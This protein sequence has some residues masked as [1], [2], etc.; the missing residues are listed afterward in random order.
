MKLCN[1]FII[2]SC[3]FL[4]SFSFSAAVSGQ[5]SGG[6]S[7]A[8]AQE[9][10]KK[11]CANCG[12]PSK[13]S[14]KSCGEVSYCSKPCQI[15]DW[16]KDHK[17]YHQ[18]F[19]LA[20]QFEEAIRS[21]HSNTDRPQDP[22]D[23]EKIKN[24]YRDLSCF[25]EKYTKLSPHDEAI[26]TCI[27][28]KKILS[29]D[30]L[31]IFLKEFFFLSEIF[32]NLP[33][34]FEQKME[35]KAIEKMN[36][37]LLFLSNS[38]LSAKG[39]KLNSLSKREHFT[40]F[41]NILE[42]T[43]SSS[44]VEQDVWDIVRLILYTLEQNISSPVLKDLLKKKPLCLEVL[45][46]ILKKYSKPTE[47][48]QYTPPCET[49]TV[50][51]QKDLFERLCPV[52]FSNNIYD[53][54]IFALMT[55]KNYVDIALNVP[56][57]LTKDLAPY[58]MK[59][60][61]KEESLNLL[62]GLNAYKKFCNA[63]DNIYTESKEADIPLN[64][65]HFD[66][67]KSLQHFFLNNET[68]EY[69]AEDLNFFRIVNLLNSFISNCRELLEGGS[70]ISSEIKNEKDHLIYFLLKKILEKRRGKIPLALLA[71][72]KLDHDIVKY[73]N[74]LSAAYSW[75]NV[76]MEPLVR[77]A[78]QSQI[79]QKKSKDFAEALSFYSEKRL[80]FDLKKFV[81][82]VEF[83]NHTYSEFYKFAKANELIANSVICS[84]ES[85]E[86][87]ELLQTF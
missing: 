4:N 22:N 32:F 21:C 57:Y 63:F 49:I 33:E 64:D 17:A 19:K 65:L 69:A 40:P 87:I 26:F 18:N 81:R 29:Q 37:L 47:I 72:I 35:L 8:K 82:E 62:V 67:I 50:E 66:F 39:K 41:F 71:E 78:E 15:Q 31:D 68:L 79:F 55:Q 77:Y 25:F 36:Q 46:R 44:K 45:F 10:L 12:E 42:K 56:D 70:E 30:F 58:F 43:I 80:S 3:F 74:F 11:P 7:A 75:K 6:S 27:L 54:E 9:P 28:N 38:S 76:D 16:K 53:D 24:F 73:I 52:L 51:N 59:L 83:D 14:C 13:Y 84:Y 5:I 60:A 1:L 61:K 48:N 2:L 20:N 34:S 85:A 86:D 23:L